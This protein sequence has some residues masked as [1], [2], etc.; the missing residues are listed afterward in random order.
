MLGA[1]W[2]CRDLRA[3]GSLEVI[4]AFV[5]ASETPLTSLSKALYWS[6]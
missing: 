4:P 5:N 1:G 6:A 3:N 2:C